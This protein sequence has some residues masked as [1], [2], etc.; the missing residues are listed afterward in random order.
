MLKP[1]QAVDV[2]IVFTPRD[3]QQYSEQIPFELNGLYTVNVTVQGEGCLLKVDLQNP[4]QALVSFGS[5]RVGQESVRRVRK[6][7]RAGGRE[8]GDESTR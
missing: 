1:N 8:G 7:G 2:P 4:A 6:E 5:L 3:V